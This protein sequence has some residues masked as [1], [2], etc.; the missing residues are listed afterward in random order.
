MV[1]FVAILCPSSG[2]LIVRFLSGMADEEVCELDL[3]NCEAS[4]EMFLE[5]PKP[6]AGD[7]ICEGTDPKLAPINCTVNGVVQ[8]LEQAGANVTVGYVGG[9]STD[10]EPITT[11]FFEAGLCPV[12]VHWHRGAEHYSLGE[13][14]ETGMGPGKELDEGGHGSYPEDEVRLGFE[15][16]YYNPE[17]P[18]F[19]TPYD[20]KFCKDMEIGETYEF[21]W[22]HSTA[23]VSVVYNECGYLLY[24]FPLY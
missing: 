9:L 15:C 13:Y 16:L 20:W 2:N 22:P 6:F 12:N 8:A 5:P 17:D 4:L 18:K 10:A 7:N 3:M 1:A 11:T 19:T 21:H 24:H 14:D 23:G